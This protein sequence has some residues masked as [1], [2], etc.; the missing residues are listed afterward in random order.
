MLGIGLAGKLQH[1]AGR[2]FL[3]IR[4]RCL[5]ARRAAKAAGQHTILCQLRFARHQLIVGNTS[6]R[7]P[8]QRSAQGRDIRQIDPRG[9]G[10]PAAVFFY[11]LPER[12][13]AA[14]RQ[15]FCRSVA[16]EL[17]REFDSLPPSA[18]LD[19]VQGIQ[20]IEINSCSQTLALTRSSTQ[21]RRHMA[22]LLW[23]YVRIAAADIY[24]GTKLDST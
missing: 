16:I 1:D 4:K 11:Q 23:R 13:Q 6:A 3:S 2:R 18:Q 24:S 7:L 20:P 22:G 14:S 15:N 5:P 17:N 19:G 21:A 8:L 10:G 12:R 9:C